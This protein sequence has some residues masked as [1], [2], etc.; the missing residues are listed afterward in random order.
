MIETVG[1]GQTETEVADVA[2]TVA[3]IVQPGGGDALQFLKSGIMEIPDV[4][5]VT[6][7]DLGDIAQSTR[8]E[9]SGALRSLGLLRDAR[10]GGLRAGAAERHRG[11]CRRARCAPRAGGARRAAA[12]RSGAPQRSPSSSSS[13]ASA[14]CERSAGAAPRAPC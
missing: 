2:D 14:G 11:A 4:L 10:G 12:A 5:V 1:V 7:G 6:K 9:L 13:T 3:V 8:R